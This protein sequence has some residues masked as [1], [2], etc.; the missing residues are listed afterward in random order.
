MKLQRLDFVLAV[1]LAAAAAAFPM[2]AAVAAAAP[3]ANPASMPD[4]SGIWAHPALGFGPQLSGPGP[5]RNKSRLPS[6]VSNFNLLVGDYTN[7]ILKPEAAEILKQRGEISLS[8]RAFPDPDNQCLQNPVPYI[9]WNF[10]IQ[11]LQQPWCKSLLLV[12]QRPQ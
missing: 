9:F 12:E 6:G 2:A 10:D 11:L 8:G 5:I 4:L 1:T 7:P 3:A